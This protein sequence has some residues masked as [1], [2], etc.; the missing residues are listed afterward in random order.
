MLLVDVLEEQGDYFSFFFG[1]E[2]PRKIG[3]LVKSSEQVATD[4]WMIRGSKRD[5]GTPL[6]TTANWVMERALTCN[7][8]I[9]ILKSSIATG[10]IM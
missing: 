10:A 6:A 8:H 9:N 5:S 4:D 7:L 2:M 3:R 1:R